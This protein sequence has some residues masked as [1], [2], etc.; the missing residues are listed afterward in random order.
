VNKVKF[1]RGDKEVSVSIQLVMLGV[2]IGC[3]AGSSATATDNFSVTW[4]Y[5]DYRLGYRLCVYP[6]ARGHGVGLRS[7]TVIVL[8]RN[9]RITVQ[10]PRYFFRT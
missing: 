4:G 3:G 1:L 2:H 10:I 5:V 9:K 6:R 7:N 8:W